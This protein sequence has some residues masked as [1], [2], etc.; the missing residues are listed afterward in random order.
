LRAERTSRLQDGYELR[1]VEVDDGVAMD[2]VD[3]TQ[4][5]VAMEPVKNE[6][7]PC[8]H[9]GAPLARDQRYCLEC[10]TPRTYLSG[11]LLQRLRAP[12]GQAQP[13]QLAQALPNGAVPYGGT[14]ASS[15]WQRGNVL[16]LIA[17]IGVL[18]LAMG[19]G[20]LIGRSGGSSSAA[21][22]PQVTV[23]GAGAGA[24]GTA[25]TPTT[26]TPEETS[27]STK[28]GSSSPAKQSKAKALAPGVGSVPSKPAPPSVLKNLHTKG[29]GG[30]YEQKSK[31]LPNVVED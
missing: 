22:A 9:C 2:P 4:P 14:A 6:T 12:A 21:P 30:S 3:A 31:N 19:V 5:T 26:S 16:T 7:E 25:T 20:V 27:S 11:M 8:A 18:L 17:G 10:G 23:V 1:G 24:A 29:S 28:S 13:G 15:T